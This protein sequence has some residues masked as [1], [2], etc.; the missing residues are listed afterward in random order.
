MVSK[1]PTVRNRTGVGTLPPHVCVYR[2]MPCFPGIEMHRSYAQA[3]MVEPGTEFGTWNGI[4]EYS[5]AAMEAVR[6]QA[7]K[8][9]NL[10]PRG[11]VEIGG[12]LYGERR[13]EV[14]RVMAAHELECR[15]ELGPRFVLAPHEETTF[16][17]L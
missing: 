15:H 5:Y 13:G 14:T 8:G 4:V 7:V 3:G 12:V 6:E 10:F 17:E 11:G 16:R 9:F 2:N 1:R